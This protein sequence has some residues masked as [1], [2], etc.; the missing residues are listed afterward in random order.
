MTP[1]PSSGYAT[2]YTVKCILSAA[3]AFLLG[4]WSVFYVQRS[5][6]LALGFG[7]YFVFDFLYDGMMD[8]VF[9]PSH[10][11]SSAIIVGHHLLGI[12]TMLSSPQTDR[13][14]S[15]WRMVT[16]GEFTSPILY[17]M[18]WHRFMRAGAASKASALERALLLLLLLMWPPLRL[19]APM[20]GLHIVCVA[21]GAWDVAFAPGILVIAFYFLMNAYFYSK[22]LGM[23]FRPSKTSVPGQGSD[24]GAKKE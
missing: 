16:V 5:A 18:L 6:D 7:A 8:V 11:N 20:V 10:T 24:V 21:D 1:A 13:V 3:S 23:Y 2:A 9:K 12:W 19:V 17:W 4:V 15:A 14:M 22:L